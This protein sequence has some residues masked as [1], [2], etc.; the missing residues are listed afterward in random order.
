MHLLHKAVAELPEEAGAGVLHRTGD[1]TE[2]QLQLRSDLCHVPEHS[3][4][5][6]HKDQQS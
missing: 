6:N 4:P 3:P 2:T 5:L 1:P